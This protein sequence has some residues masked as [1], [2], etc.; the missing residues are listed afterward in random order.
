MIYQQVNKRTKNLSLA[1]Y[2]TA[3][4]CNQLNALPISMLRFESIN[5]YQKSP[6]IELY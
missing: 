2:H 1:T 6:K 4:S 3:H 5:F